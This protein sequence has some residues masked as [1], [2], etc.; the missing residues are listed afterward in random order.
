MLR[1]PVVGSSLTD[2]MFIDCK[3][4]L[5]KVQFSLCGVIYIQRGR[6]YLEKKKTDPQLWLKTNISDD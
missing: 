6:I 4:F 5:C 1:A 2:G 3:I